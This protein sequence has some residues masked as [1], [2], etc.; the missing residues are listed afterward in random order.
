MRRSRTALISKDR[1]GDRQDRI[2]DPTRARDGPR[3]GREQARARVLR[4]LRRG[5]GRGAARR[6]A[7]AAT[8]RSKAS[9]AA[10]STYEPVLAEARRVGSAVEARDVPADPD[11]A[12]YRDRDEAMRLANDTDMGLTA[13][14]YGA[15]DEVKL[16][17]G[18]ASRPASPM[19]TAA[20]ARP[21]APGRVPAVRR[22]EGLRLLGQGDRFGVLP[23]ALPARTV[24]DRGR[25]NARVPAASGR[26]R[27]ARRRRRLPRA[28]GVHAPHPVRGRPRD[29]PPGAARPASRAHDARPRLRPADRRGLRAQAHLLL[30]RQSRRRLAASP[31]RR[32]RERAGR[33]R[34]RSTSTP[35]RRWRPPTARAPRGCRSAC[36]AGTSA[37][38]SRNRTRA[39]GVSPA[40][41]PVRRSP[42]SP[43]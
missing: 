31:A 27:E 4:A 16:V 33:A 25:L 8:S 36:C 18:R 20:R 10:A 23:A 37:P 38:I 35:T 43:P 24:A 41:T 40:P 9:S 14:F 29:H 13:G 42:P 32:R 12:R 26:D 17:P 28:R 22:M 34:S 11:G 3:P 21:P 39:S 1:A 6:S 30:G 5:P 19:R 2:G 7:A 15:P